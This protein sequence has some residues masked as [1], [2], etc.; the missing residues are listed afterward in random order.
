LRLLEKATESFQVDIHWL[1]RN[2]MRDYNVTNT[3]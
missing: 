2:E 1:T 3:D